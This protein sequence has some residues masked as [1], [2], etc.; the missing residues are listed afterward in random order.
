MSAVG[1]W[2]ALESASVAPSRAEYRHAIWGKFRGSREDFG[3]I[4]R[5]PSFG[6]GGVAIETRLSLGTEDVLDV[7]ASF[8]RVVGE[9][10][11]AIYIYRSPA[12]DEAGR[13]G[14][15]KQFVEFAP[16]GL[17][18]AA[19]AAAGLPRAFGLAQTS[20]V[21]SRTNPSGRVVV[22]DDAVADVDAALERTVT[23]G[24]DAL[25]SGPTREALVTFYGG[26]LAGCAPAMLVAPAPLDPEAMAALLLPLERATADRLSLAG[27]I[28]SS[29]FDAGSMRTAWD[30]IVYDRVPDE[31][32][33]AVP[34]S[35]RAQAETLVSALLD[36]DPARLTAP[37]RAVASSAAPAPVA[38]APAPA[39]HAPAAPRPGHASSVVRQLI[40]FALSPDR[41]RDLRVTAPA[42]VSARDREELGF[43]LLEVH[44]QLDAPPAL[45]HPLLDARR[46]H[47]Q[48]KL[49]L[50]RDAAL[51]LDPSLADLDWVL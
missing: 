40:D 48:Y 12:V 6:S 14:L 26:I 38:V 13:R 28:M 45:D 29:R 22:L 3:W 47:L 35:C 27:W 20:D 37:A 44:E 41:H 4:G 15:E 21:S 2:P 8:W 51:R 49:N 30:G 18:R 5:S 32:V 43:A 42:R 36:R 46:L 17:P 24:I 9:R 39:P 31:F 11:F 33:S 10:C 1:R 34:A 7:A 16:A 19:L 50:I 23:S 25:Q